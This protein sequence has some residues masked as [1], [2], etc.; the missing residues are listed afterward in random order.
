MRAREVM[1]ALWD[2]LPTCVIE[3]RTTA[4]G[5][6]FPDDARLQVGRAEVDA[7]MVESAD[8]LRID[9]A[10]TVEAIGRLLA[11]RPALIRQ[12]ADFLRG[13]KA[14]LVVA[15][16]PYLAGGIAAAVGLDCVA[17]SNFT[18][19]WIVEPFMDGK[20]ALLREIEEGYSRMRTLLQLP[21]GHRDG[22]RMFARVEAM[23]LLSGKRRLS[24]D[25]VRRRMGA[26]DRPM[27]WV[28]LRGTQSPEI[29]AAGA[30]GAGEY[31]FLTTDFSL[32]GAASNVQA[33]RLG[34]DLGVSDLV[35]GCD[36][37]LGK[38]GYSLVSECVSAKARLLHVP[39]TGFREDAITGCEAP[40]YTVVRELA[41]GTF[42]AGD[43]RAGLDGILAK[44]PP[45]EVHPDGG[46]KACAA[47][48][49]AML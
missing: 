33:V 43:W 40:R 34:N 31:L 45:V 1:S 6:L 16:I 19:N 49:A 9:P 11:R 18:W 8:S 48:I 2:M 23:P 13:R 12:E 47:A 42:A 3:V 24:R 21:F 44:T 36:V 17:I 4:A 35:A 5:H 27:V 39:R 25:E 32:A 7:G 28:A 41:A 15:D 14:T 26:G 30:S 20:P 22:L 29:F 38:L 10:G 46:A 37:V